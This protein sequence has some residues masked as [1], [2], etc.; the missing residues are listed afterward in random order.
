M[1]R[2]SLSTGSST[3]LCSAHCA[4]NWTAT[5]EGQAEVWPTQEPD[6]APQ[7]R[8]S[9]PGG[10]PQTWQDSGEAAPTD[11]ALPPRSIE[12]ILCELQKKNEILILK[13]LSLT[14]LNMRAKREQIPT[15][16]KFT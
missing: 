12:M 11:V 1:T 16:I 4:T 10:A 6:P 13:D 8:F 14:I 9:H 2:T 3:T 15:L 7:E 5:R